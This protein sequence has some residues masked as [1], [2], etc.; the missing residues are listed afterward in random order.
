MPHALPDTLAVSIPQ[1]VPA[2]S[3]MRSRLAHETYGAQMALTIRT[4]TQPAVTIYRSSLKADKLVYLALVNK[5]LKY[6]FGRSRI[7]YIGTTK[8]GVARIAQSAAAKAKDLLKLQ[9][10]RDLE[11]YIVTARGV[12]NVKTW[13]KL[14]SELLH[15]FRAK[16]GDVPR[17]NKQGIGRTW[18]AEPRY[19]TPSRLE[20]VIARYST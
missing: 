17:C 3:A 6:P 12:Q 11:F 18:Q 1:F 19:F 4:T 8:A 14:E 16:F 7:A 13:R 9:G 2:F 20:S 5:P 10:I 15:A